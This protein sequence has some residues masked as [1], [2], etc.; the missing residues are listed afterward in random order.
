MSNMPN[1]MITKYIYLVCTN[2]SDP[3]LRFENL[4]MGAKLEFERL[5]GGWV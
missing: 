5:L 2:F 4:S 3:G 1:K